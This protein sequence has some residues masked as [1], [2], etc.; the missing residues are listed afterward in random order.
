MRSIVSGFHMS[1][2]AG[3][4][5]ATEEGIANAEVVRKLQSRLDQFIFLY[6]AFLGVTRL[7]VDDLRNGAYR[8]P[9]S[10][11]LAVLVQ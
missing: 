10:C 7:N 9:Q 4:S 11:S 6:S 2:G 5:C 8:I 3:I 1:C